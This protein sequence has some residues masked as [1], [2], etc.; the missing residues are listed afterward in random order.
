M[1]RTNSVSSG[2]SS[3]E[4]PD[5]FSDEV[6]DVVVLRDDG[7]RNDDEED[8]GDDKVLQDVV[9]DAHL[10]VTTFLTQSELI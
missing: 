6:P 9:V 3:G 8:D 1:F 4:I 10:E 2:K 7:D 5:S